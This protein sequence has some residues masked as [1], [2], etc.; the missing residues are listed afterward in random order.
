MKLKYN[1]DLEYWIQGFGVHNPQDKPFEVDEERGEK[2]LKT[3]Y[4]NE[5]KEKRYKRKNLKKKGD[6]K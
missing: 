2:M 5:I 1:G 4:F 3:G 6:D